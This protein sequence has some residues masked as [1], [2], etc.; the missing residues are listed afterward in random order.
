MFLAAFSALN[1][2]LHT[3][4][5]EWTFGH[6]HEEH[7]LLLF[8]PFAL[9]ASY[10]HTTPRKH[11]CTPSTQSCH[12]I[13]SILPHPHITPVDGVPK[14]RCHK[15]TLQQAVEVACHGLIDQTTV[16]Y[17]RT[18]K[19]DRKGGQQQG[20]TSLTVSVTWQHKSNFYYTQPETLYSCS[21]LLWV[22][23]TYIQYIIAICWAEI[24]QCWYAHSECH[25]ASHWTTLPVSAYAELYQSEFVHPP[26]AEAHSPVVAVV[27]VERRLVACAADVVVLEALL[28]AL[29]TATT[30]L[31][32]TAEG[33]GGRGAGN[34]MK[35]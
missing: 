31:S 33:W 8:T 3:I 19:Q 2:H 21:A 10:Y 7:R 30:L 23:C 25:A 12:S 22:R 9:Y 5:N 35:I 29:F 20:Y 18:H 11:I 32:S 28:I 16:A 1:S 24:H 13:T 14:L 4:C 26:A 27:E 6:P 34:S 15:Q 17:T